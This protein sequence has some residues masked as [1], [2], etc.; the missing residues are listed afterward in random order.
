MPLPWTIAPIAPCH[1][2]MPVLLWPRRA[3]SSPRHACGLNVSGIP[4]PCG[5]GQAAPCLGLGSR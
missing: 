5:Q 3:P 1:H 2:M 4:R